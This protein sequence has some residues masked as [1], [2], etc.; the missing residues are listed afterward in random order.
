MRELGSPRSVRNNERQLNESFGMKTGTVSA[1]KELFNLPLI[2]V[3]YILERWLVASEITQTNV[4]IDKI[5]ILQLHQQLHVAWLSF[6]M[7]RHTLPARQFAI[8]RS[9]RIRHKQ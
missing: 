6:N 5:E 3:R 2:N 7:L 8:K 4:N 9:A 1:D